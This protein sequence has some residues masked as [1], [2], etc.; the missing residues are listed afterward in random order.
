MNKSLKKYL[1]F[2]RIV[3]VLM[4]FFSR[5]TIVHGEGITEKVT[6][7]ILSDASADM[8]NQKSVSWATGQ[9]KKALQ[10]KKIN[11]EICFNL[12][13]IHQ[14][15]ERIV[16]TP[17]ESKLAHDIARQ[18]GVTLPTTA[19]SF[20]LIKGIIKNE[21]I[22]MATGFDA[23]GLTYAILE[24]VD[25][26]TYSKNPVTM[27]KEIEH[28]VEQ[29]VNS[30]RSMTRLFVSEL[31]DKSWFYD[32]DFWESYLTMLKTQRFNRFSLT[33]G[34][35]YDSPEQVLDSYF[36]FAY[37]FLVS[38]P[39]YNVK[40]KNLP[41]GEQEK[42]L[43]MLKFISSEAARRGLHFQLGLWGHA[44]ECV[45]SPEVNYV[46]EGLSQEIHADYCQKALKTLLQACPDIDGITFRAHYESGIKDGSK[47]FWETV[48]KG[49][50]DCG[51]RVEIDLHAK[52]ISYNQVEMALN[53]GQ[54][55][56][57]SPKL[58]AEHMGLPAHQAAIR[59]MERVPSS[60]SNNP[61][62]SISRYSYSDFLS[63]DR[64]Y[65]ILYRIWPGMQK[66][67]LWGDP[68]LA[69]GYGRYAGFCG[70]LGIE[71]CDP[72]CFKG[73]QGSGVS[74]ERQIYAD[75]SLIPEGGSWRKYLYTYRIWGRHL[76]NPDANPESYRRFL[77]FEYGEA[78]SSM[79]KAL[80]NSSRIIPLITSSHSPAI[81]AM[82]YWPEMYTNIPITNSGI[83]HPYGDTP[84]PKVFGRVSPLDPAMFSPVNEFVDDLIKGVPSSRYSAIDVAQVLENFATTSKRQLSIA[85]QN[86]SDVKGASFRRAFIDASV[87]N[88]LGIFW[89]Q[90][91]R[92]SVAYTLYEKKNELDY[93]R[94]AV[95]FYQSARDEWKNII[96]LTKNVYVDKLNFGRFPHIRGNWSDR[97]PAIEQDLAYME[98]M[99]R[100]KIGNAAPFPTSTS[101]SAS[102]WLKLRPQIPNG[103]HAVPKHFIPGKP[104]EIF[105]NTESSK[106]KTVKLYYR[107]VNQVEAYNVI[108]M[109]NNN[110]KWSYSIS[111]D[112]TNSPY[113]IMYY[114]EFQDNNNN[115]WLYPGFNE[116]FANQP[117]FNIMPLK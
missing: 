54:P 26:I 51:R 8:V 85:K 15:G 58:S 83:L 80:A 1:H 2:F 42:N 72:L 79:E 74:S 16:I 86:V 95:Y 30:I 97:L 117:Y 87:Q 57:V 10:D 34:L 100:D 61:R 90:K 91:L 63:N 21:K 99:L 18:S 31:E 43:E 38:V 112:F 9:L 36:I 69:S 75:E 28:S 84:S 13:G 76:Y 41:S 82:T 104:I 89:A 107:H 92:A 109:T 77:R 102:S 6:L 59:E 70:S 60:T 4:I 7:F 108:P 71:V 3:G 113:P 32:K 50:A 81:S 17:S 65:G 68:A 45:N 25:R 73:R 24:L 52:G 27:L 22:V 106:I 98:K 111:G 47:S 12:E 11:A 20:A 94:D 40:V 14:P 96:D 23:S 19:E 5:S 53:T 110:G 67:L 93:L 35:G 44:Y 88:D 29:P 46:I 55:V 114:F 64:D 105:L 37:P 115:A 78:A 116:D 66:I 33:L 48:F 101:S 49:V 103:K 56:L 62:N 39:G